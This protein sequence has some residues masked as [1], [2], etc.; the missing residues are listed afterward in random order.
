MTRQGVPTPAPRLGASSAPPTG[1]CGRGHR[2]EGGPSQP[3]TRASMIVRPTGVSVPDPGGSAPDLVP[4]SP[5][6]LGRRLHGGRTRGGAAGPGGHRLSG[7]RNRSDT[8]AVRFR[9]PS[10]A[11]KLRAGRAPSAPHRLL[12]SLRCGR[13]GGAAPCVPQ[14]PQRNR[15]LQVG[16][17]RGSAVSSARVALIGASTRP[18]SSRPST[19]DGRDARQPRFFDVLASLTAYKRAGT[20]A[21][22]L[23]HREEGDS[24]SYGRPSLSRA[25]T[26]TTRRMASPETGV[27]PRRVAARR[28]ARRAC[29]KRASTTRRECSFCL[30]LACESVARRG[31]MPAQRFHV[32]RGSTRSSPLRGQCHR[33]GEGRGCPRTDSHLSQAAA[34]RH[35]R[36]RVNPPRRPFIVGIA[37]GDCA[38]AGA[39]T[40]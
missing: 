37:N 14:S 17:S 28:C 22:A 29:A 30:R 34:G 3:T 31:K 16:Y 40:G 6:R 24:N 27:P 15:D 1:L 39:T 9:S 26:V 2:R 32:C 23:G 36:C 4:N 35:G 5:L 8:C 7:V 19:A 10:A 11:A 18:S 12:R 33:P 25:G 20:I 13:P 21:P 38:E